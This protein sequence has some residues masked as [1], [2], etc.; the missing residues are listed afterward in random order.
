M[1]AVDHEFD[2][3]ETTHFCYMAQQELLP[4]QNALQSAKYGYVAS[5]CCST[6]H[7]RCRLSVLNAKAGHEYLRE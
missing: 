4:D 6:K 1:L 3:T 5:L 7:S 2:I